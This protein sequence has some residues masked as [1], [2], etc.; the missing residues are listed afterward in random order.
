M[1]SSSTIVPVNDTWEIPFE[2][3]TNLEWL[4]SG[5][6][7]A[8]FRG[9]LNGDNVAVKKVRELAE[10]DIEHLRQLRHPN[11]ISFR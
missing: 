5:S 6:Q 3:I 8:V 1:A 11:V 2:L 9:Q 7:G 4:G 10:T